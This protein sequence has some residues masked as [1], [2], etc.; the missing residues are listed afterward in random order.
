MV[1]NSPYLNS[2][3]SGSNLSREATAVRG[4]V[5]IVSVARNFFY[6]GPARAVV[7]DRADEIAAV[8][9][10]FAYTF[11][12]WGVYILTTSD[13]TDLAAI[14]QGL[15][16]LDVA[17]HL[18]GIDP[19]YCRL[20]S[21]WDASACIPNDGLVPVTSQEYP[22]AP[23]LIIGTNND[24]PAHI[25]EKD[26]SHDAFYY[27]LVWYLGVPS[28]GGPA[29]PQP[30]PTTPPSPDPHPADEDNGTIPSSGADVMMSGR[31][32]GPGEDVHS[33]NGKYHLSY[34][35][36]GNLVLYDENW[37]PM[38]STGTADN[39]A[40]VTAMQG[41]G[42]LVVYDATGRPVWAS[43]TPQ[44][45]GAFLV[46]QNDGNLVIYASDL[47]PVWSTGTVR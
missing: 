40:G 18:F 13:P 21:T 32:I 42:N 2:L 6:A 34:Q 10:G 31:E 1:P 5:G 23:N 19:L 16:L 38:W 37:E 12:Y 15:A 46:V 35:G 17:H 28:R 29:P 30:G 44:Y 22:G 7:P 47:Q 25:Q 11:E 33:E 27:A 14:D 4:R 36:D 26:W 20:V 3:N 39:S 24:G 43:D 45:P 9:Y 41:D 8:L